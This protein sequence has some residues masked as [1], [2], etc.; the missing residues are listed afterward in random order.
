MKMKEFLTN[1]AMSIAIG[2][3]ALRFVANVSAK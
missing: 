2:Y 3:I 1:M